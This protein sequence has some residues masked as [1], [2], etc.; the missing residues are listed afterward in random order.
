MNTFSAI[1]SKGLIFQK[2]IFH[3]KKFIS[4]CILKCNNKQHLTRTNKNFNVDAD[5]GLGFTRLADICVNVSLS[6]AAPADV[7]KRCLDIQAGSINTTTEELVF[8]IQVFPSYLFHRLHRINWR[9]EWLV[10]PTQPPLIPL[11]WNFCMKFSSLNL[12]GDICWDVKKN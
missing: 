6:T 10:I 8:L 11:Q 7:P 3:I 4:P 9:K 5:C 2:Y 12:L 1:T